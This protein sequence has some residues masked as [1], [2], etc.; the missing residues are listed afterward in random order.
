MDG[1]EPRFVDVDNIILQYDVSV[2]AGSCTFFFAIA[3]N[4]VDYEIYAAIFVIKGKQARKEGV[5]CRRIIVINSMRLSKRKTSCC[6][7]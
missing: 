6:Q 7:R 2:E 1:A 5:I 4:T 3:G